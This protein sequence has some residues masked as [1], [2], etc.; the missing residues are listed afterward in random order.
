MLRGASPQ[1]VRRR[2]ADGLQ[3]PPDLRHVLDAD[4]VVLDV[5]PVGDVGDAAAELVGDLADRPELLGV[6]LAAGDPDPEHEVAVLDVGVLQ[7]PGAAAVDP[8]PALG[9]EPPP[10]ESRAQVGR[11]DRVEALAGVALLD[12]GPDVEAVVV[13]L[14]PLG[15]VE[16][17]AAAHGPL[18]LVALGAA[19][20]RVLLLSSIAQLTGGRRPRRPPGGEE[21]E[22]SADRARST[23]AAG[24][25]AAG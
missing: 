16:R 14:R 9:V 19:W 20:H 10:A 13:L 6:Q 1:V 8:R 4:P 12:P 7:R 11:V 5:L 22:V 18:A 2:Q 23:P 15:A 24:R 17:A 25:R 3:P 21:G